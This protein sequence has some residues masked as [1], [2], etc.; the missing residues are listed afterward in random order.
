M[1]LPFWIVNWTNGMT[2]DLTTYVGN[3]ITDLSTPLT[4]IIAVGVGLIVISG[5]INAIRG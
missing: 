1:I 5:I 2:T 3:V 4:I